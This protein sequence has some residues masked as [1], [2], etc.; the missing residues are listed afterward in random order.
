VALRRVSVTTRRAVWLHGWR[1]APFFVA[2]VARPTLGP[3]EWFGSFAARGWQL[4]RGVMGRALG[5]LLIGCWLVFAIMTFAVVV[6]PLA[7]SLLI[8][9]TR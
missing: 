4:F 5:R 2:G 3:A 7:V 1:P 9:A 8:E 6:L